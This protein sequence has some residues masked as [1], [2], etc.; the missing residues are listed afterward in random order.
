MNTSATRIYQARI[1]I[2]E[3]SFI[4]PS[5]PQPTISQALLDTHALFQDAVNYHL[6]A[7]AGMVGNNPA[8]DSVAEH[9]SSRIREIWEAKPKGQVRACT[10]QQ[11]IA[12]SL[13]LTAP[14]F[15]EAVA[16]IFADSPCPEAL[17]M[18]FESIIYA[19]EKGKGVIQQQGNSILPRLCDH[20]FSGNFDYSAKTLGHEEEKRKL[21]HLL[22]EERSP[23][24][25]ESL[26]QFASK[27]SLGDTGIKLQERF[28]DPQEEL[29]QVISSIDELFATLTQNKKYAEVLERYYQD[30]NYAA[31]LKCELTGIK[32]SIKTGFRPRELARKR[33]CAPSLKHLTIFFMYAP[34]KLSADLLQIEL[35]KAKKTKNQDEINSCQ[36]NGE[37]ATIQARGKRGYVY[38][39]F[40]ALSNWECEAPN[41]YSKEWD[42]LAFKEA[43]KTL[44]SYELKTKERK[45]QLAEVE[46]NISAMLNPQHKKIPNIQD[47]EEH[48]TLPLLAGDK[49]YK[50]ACQVLQELGD[51]L[52]EEDFESLLENEGYSLSSRSING[53]KTLK[54]HWLAAYK[55]NK[56]DELHLIELVSELQAELGHRMGSVTLFRALAQA[57]YHD[58]WLSKA[59]DSDKMNRAE[60]ILGAL[61]QLHQLRAQASKL[62][63]PVRITAAD[64]NY[65]A[66]LIQLLDLKSLA[67]LEVY[68]PS[69]EDVLQ[70]GL[71]ARNTKGRWQAYAADLHYSAPRAKR[72]QLRMGD[73]TMPWM[74]NMLKPLIDEDECLVSPN[75]KVACTLSINTHNNEQDSSAWINFAVRLDITKLQDK[76]AK[77]PRW[78]G[79]F[80]GTPQEH[81]HL[82]WPSTYGTKKQAP[83]WQNKQ[84][85]KEGFFVLSVD[86]GLRYAAAWGLNHIQQA[87]QLP[88]S[89]LIGQSGDSEHNRW[90]GKPIKSGIMR[91]NGEGLHA[92]RCQQAVQTPSGIRLASR[93]EKEQARHLIQNKF[94]KHTWWT[95]ESNITILEL[96][97]SVLDAFKRYLSRYRSF[98][99][100]F[101]R[102]DDA[103]QEDWSGVC[104]KIHQYIT[105]GKHQYQVYTPF[106]QAQEKGD[107]KEAV[108]LFKDNVWL[109]QHGLPRLAE[110]VTTL[111]LPRKKD[112]WQWMEY[113]QAGAIGSGIMTVD[114]KAPQL[115]NIPKVWHQGGISIA[116]IELLLGLRRCLQ[117][118]N[119]LLDTVPGERGIQGRAS[120]DQLV[121][122]PCPFLLEKIDKMREMRCNQIAGQIVAQALGVRL[123]PSRTGKNEVLD[124][125]HGEYERIPGR[126]IAD[127][128][129]LEDLSRYKTSI[130][131]TKGENS[132]LMLWSHRSITNKVKQIL[133][134]IYGIPVLF[135]NPIYTSKFDCMS[136]EAGFR[137]RKIKPRAPK[138]STD[139]KKEKSEDSMQRHFYEKLLYHIQEEGEDISKL[140]LFAPQE[141]GEYFISTGKEITMPRNA[142][143]N[144]AINIG[145]RALAA[146]NR[147]ELLHR[148]RLEKNEKGLIKLRKT[149]A[150]IREKSLN[151]D[152]FKLL[153]KDEMTAGFSAI[154]YTPQ[155]S[156]QASALYEE[157]GHCAHF[158]HGKRLWGQVISRK[159]QRCHEINYRILQKEGFENEAKLV[160]RKW[161]SLD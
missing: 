91:L 14:S 15:E 140:T 110:A 59:A 146:P 116:R 25:L 112:S 28:W 94:H 73:T 10:L 144:A 68:D 11:S 108:R 159:W 115:D 96:Q 29:E 148:L 88:H 47:E 161:L 30:N 122:D 97:Q 72:D 26:T 138:E 123:I 130:D 54:E 49:R 90:F 105:Y 21:Q 142:D 86:L 158:I 8:H 75:D 38:L 102:L 1:N 76:I 35:G 56:A 79:Q 64:P 103:H 93:D 124:V 155:S 31:I 46:S 70:L 77:A 107:L 151:K 80:N 37:D 129:I 145:W 121:I 16:D 13:N 52:N 20:K 113:K 135:T 74:Q 6:V 132:S 128:V 23:E 109:M 137:A 157:A 45:A 39:G 152:L 2:K 147:F 7:L 141:G 60:D 58:I 4:D 149:G 118:M 133:E 127:F 119:R 126:S 125:I 24:N 154:F 139:N 98:L 61:V 9:F 131:R 55:V 71:L 153:Q 95:V 143:V 100:W 33:K 89:R 41:M 12:R 22:Q 156:T 78:E 92:H 44:H 40:S 27:M 136:A 53:W 32:K 67:K 18:V 87:A 101:R 65:S 117:S 150:N 85:Q 48:S 66:R 120:F 42:I 19:M 34:C 17:P 36:Y 84:I 57:Q 3:S 160:A 81:L 51:E 83:W 5:T 106:L 43:L 50:L 111:L 63:R 114:G 69:K 99:S 62:S 134:D 82:H 104:N